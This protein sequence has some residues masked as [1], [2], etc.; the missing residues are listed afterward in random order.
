MFR[1]RALFAVV[2]IILCSA[3][4]SSAAEIPFELYSG[5]PAGSGRGTA[6]ADINGD[7][8]DDYIVAF[9]STGIIRGY[10]T[11]PLAILFSLTG[12]DSPSTVATGDLDGD[13]DIDIA[14][15]QFDNIPIEGDPPHPA[16]ESEVLW[17]ENP[18]NGGGGWVA[19]G[20]SLLVFEGMRDIALFDMDADGDL[21]ILEAQSGGYTW[22]AN[23]GSP[24]DGGW[25]IHTIDSSA[26][27]PWGVA[28]VDLDGDGDFDVV[29]TDVTGDVVEWFESEDGNA[30]GAPDDFWTS[31]TIDGSFN[32]ASGVAVGDI[33][34]DGDPDVIAAAAVA[35]QISWYANPGWAE[36]VV[37]TG[38][39]GASSVEVVDLDLDGDLDILATAE[40]DDDLAWF[41]NTDGSGG[42]WTERTLDAAAD[43]AVDAVA[44]DFDGDGDPDI[45]MA[46][47]FED[48]L[49]QWTNKKIHRRFFD[50][51]PIEIRSELAEPR[52]I[53][54][55]DIN[56]DGLQDVVTALWTGGDVVAYLGVTTEGTG[57]WTNTVDESF[58]SAR[59]VAVADMDGDG[60]IDILGA[61]VAAD[62]IRWWENNGAAV[63]TWTA[64]TIVASYNGA[65]R[66]EPA[67]FDRDGDMDVAVAAFDGDDVSWME[68]TNGIGTTWSR[69][70]FGVFDGA[71]DLAVGD[72]NSDGAPDIVASAYEDDLVEFFLNSPTGGLWSA[73]Q[74]GVL[75][76]GPRGVDLADVDGDGDLDL[77]VVVRN[78]EDILWFANN[79]TGASWT[80]H[81][82]GTGYFPDGVAVRAGDLD[83]DGD[84][85]VAATNQ[86]GDDVIVW[87][88]DGDG[89]SWTK[90][91]MEQSLDST[92]DLDL[93]D[94]NRDGRLD[95]AVAAGGTADS[96]TWYPNV[97]DQFSQVYYDDAPSVIET[98]ALEPLLAV[99]VGHQG[100]TV[101]DEDM[102]LSRL[103]LEFVREDGTTPLTSTEINNLLARLELYRD[104]NNDAY[105]SPG[106]TLAATD[107]YISLSGGV[108]TWNLPD[109]GAQLAVG[110]AEA[111]FF[112]VVAT[113]L[114]T[115]PVS[116]SKFIVRIPAGGALAEDAEFDVLI[117]SEESNGIETDVIAVG[118]AIFSDDFESGN[119]NEWSNVVGG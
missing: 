54:V 112:F 82:V 98:G 94:I 16:E 105:F 18:L 50:D 23:D 35:D 45:V 57:W 64:H 26:T 81:N 21:D 118:S 48:R 116:P 39:D 58:A 3:H 19:H 72:L 40:N 28:A 4:L 32:N 115:V 104:V 84:V 119:T 7:G 22:A 117:S 73:G 49:F 67:D 12:F 38:F 113:S 93:A 34:R 85:D 106:D 56:G 97:G 41:E 109:G 14:V 96:L 88:N 92:W 60:D 2:V 90:Y 59:D 114:S 63:P 52:A 36:T 25:V 77:V 107:E 65:H 108:L 83:D 103:T 76:D 9:E 61:A 5:Y 53:E 74:V 42:A 101:R 91:S 44:A 11:Y 8:V 75:L 95:I 43:G 68:N 70:D 89:T 20:V 111:E 66:V 6:A 86:D 46:A 69:H 47:L 71:F 17:L 1:V 110:P 30:D 78:D 31:H 62:A 102:E 99:L 79:G 100:R 13:G 10:T 27:Q 80:E 87:K 24:A 29:G 55:A 15:G 37:A 33:D 51:D